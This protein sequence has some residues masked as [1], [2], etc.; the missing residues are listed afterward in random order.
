MREKQAELPCTARLALHTARSLGSIGSTVA[1][2]AALPGRP[3]CKRVPA[4]LGVGKGC[5]CAGAR[6]S[7]GVGA[8]AGR[9]PAAARAAQQCW[10]QRAP[11]PAGGGE[12]PRVRRGR[13]ARHACSTLHAAPA[14]LQWC[15]GALVP[16][17][18][19]RVPLEQA[20][21]AASLCAAALRSGVILLAPR[22]P[23]A[24]AAAARLL[25]GACS[26]VL[27]GA[28][29]GAGACAGLLAAVA[30]ARVG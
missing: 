1:W 21:P 28:A 2:S 26:I 5:A 16:G 17:R 9:F 30:L 8:P 22:G 11:Q 3:S 14:V 6:P 19:G 13:L 20:R 25:W 10:Q 29:G 18:L 12:P 23:R 7:G 15:A 27:E 4:G 24:A